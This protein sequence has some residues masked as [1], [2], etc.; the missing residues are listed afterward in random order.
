VLV[1]EKL[2]AGYGKLQILND[3]FISVKKGQ[4]V[5]LVGANAS[6][7]TTL[8]KVISGFI[9]PNN[10][11]IKIHGKDVTLLPTWDRAING[12]ATVSQGGGLFGQMTVMENLLVASVHSRARKLRKNS[13]DFVMKLFPV[14]QEREKQLAQTLSGGEQQMLSIARSLMS[15]PELLVLD[16]P[17]QGLAPVIIKEM[18]LKIQ[19]LNQMGLTVLLIE[20]NVV[21]SLKICNHAYVLEHGN[22][23][24]SDS[25][26]NLLNNAGMK[27]AYLGI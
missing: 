2:S 17:S 19:E 20:Q 21:E 4:I 14:L 13:I 27:S 26:K 12:L 16:E 23:V 1:I 25:G 7:K 3:I 11:K 5:S 6:G 8:V 22:I 24:M 15:K 18:F 10:G 9:K